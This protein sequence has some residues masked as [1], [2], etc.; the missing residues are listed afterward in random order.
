MGAEAA[1]RGAR[2]KEG[3]PEHTLSLSLSVCVCAF[4]IGMHGHRIWRGLL[5]GRRRRILEQQALQHSGRARARARF[6]A[7]KSLPFRQGLLDREPAAKK[8]LRL[9]G[10]RSRGSV[11][12]IAPRCLGA[13][14]GRV[15]LGAARWFLA[16]LWKLPLSLF[17]CRGSGGG[18]LG[19]RPQE[20]LD[21]VLVHFAAPQ[22]D[23][24]ELE[25]LPFSLRES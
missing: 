13:L 16:V 1:K 9:S 10:G 11:F 25:E 17:F 6:A 19:R 22:V 14:L 15:C 8:S 3:E 18:G 20:P 12:E 23:F 5:D 21:V 7:P 4:R 2:V 24:E